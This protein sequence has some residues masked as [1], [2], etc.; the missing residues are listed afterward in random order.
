MRKVQHNVLLALI[1]E[2]ENG[3][4]ELLLGRVTHEGTF[5]PKDSS[6]TLDFLRIYHTR[7][8]IEVAHFRSKVGIFLRLE[9]LGR[10]QLA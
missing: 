5:Q 4:F 1:E 7:V 9:Q 10:S 3:I 6:C 8:G 2:F